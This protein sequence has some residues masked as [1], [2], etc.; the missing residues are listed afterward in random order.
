MP[1][2]PAS[3]FAPGDDFFDKMFF[4]FFLGA[5]NVMWLLFPRAPSMQ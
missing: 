5:L 3:L 2:N 4:F 1:W